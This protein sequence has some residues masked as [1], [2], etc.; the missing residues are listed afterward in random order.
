MTPFDSVTCFFVFEPEFFSLCFPELTDLFF[1]K[2]TSEKLPIGNLRLTVFDS[3]TYFFHFNL[4]FSLF[5]LFELTD[6]LF[7]EIKTHRPFF[8]DIITFSLFRLLLISFGDN[9]FEVLQGFG[10]NAEK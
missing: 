1:A 2:L 6:L 4:N 10:G 8:F 7:C 5:G 9:I 3:V